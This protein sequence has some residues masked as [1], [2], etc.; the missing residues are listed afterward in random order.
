MQLTFAELR[1]HSSNDATRD[2]TDS[3]A[4][5]ALVTGGARGLGRA[6]AE[7]LAANGMSVII[8][9]VLADVGGVAA[10]EIAERYGVDAI[11]LELDIADEPSVRAA[12]GS[13]D[14]RFGCLDVLVN[15]AAVLGLVDG[16]R[17][18]LL[19]LPLSTWQRTLDVNLTGTFLMCREA[20][21]LMQRGRWGRVVNI[22]SRA[23]RAKPIAINGH[24]AAS[25]AGMLGLSRALAA[26][27][28]RDGITVN[29]VA[30]SMMATD[31]NAGDGDAFYARGAADTVL[32][33]LPTIEEMANVVGFLCSDQAGSMT[34]AIVDVNAG[35]FM[36]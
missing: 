15:N 1:F 33:R 20:I 35:A 29:C 22:S 13:V 30:P 16:E 24:Y 23:A 3:R 10:Q 25:K 11:A 7:R 14:R 27:V 9:D 26:E 5:V 34:G 6:I 28:G 19:R 21:P 12:L 4:R 31:I 32:G 18:P 8:G 17:V 36:P 2:M